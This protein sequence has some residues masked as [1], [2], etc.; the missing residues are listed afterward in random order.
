M[1]QRPSSITLKDIIHHVQTCGHCAHLKG[2]THKFTKALLQ[3][4]IMAAHNKKPTNA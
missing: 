1:N 4:A 2:E 3:R